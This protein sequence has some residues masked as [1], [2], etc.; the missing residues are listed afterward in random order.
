MRES[1]RKF[2]EPLWRRVAVTAFCASWAAWELYNGEQ[3]WAL[4]AGALAAYCAWTF[5]IKFDQNEKSD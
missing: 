3:F 5:I 1:D 2:F 4:L